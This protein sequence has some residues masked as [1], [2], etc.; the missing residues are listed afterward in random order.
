MK[1][2]AFIATALRTQLAK[3]PALTLLG[4]AGLA[5]AAICLA[6]ALI[7]GV[8]ISPEGNL[9]DTATFDAALGF[10]MLTLAVLASGIPWRSRERRVWTSLLIGLTLYA[11]A[12][13]TV[14]AFRGLDPRFSRVAGSIDQAAGGIFFLVALAIMLCFTTVAVKY[15]L[16]PATPLTVGVRYGALA[17]WVAFGVGIWMS[18]VT[19]GRVVPEAGNLLVVHALGFHGLQ[20]IPGVALLLRW[21]G[22]AQSVARRRVHCA[23]LAWLTACLAV[24]WQS[25]TGRPI[26]E[27]SPA[28]AGAALCL[29]VFGLAVFL[30][31]RAWLQSDALDSDRQPASPA[32][33]AAV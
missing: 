12:I 6:A 26:A 1:R 30:A 10:F 5:L 14:Q 19:R 18:L 28:T 33:D 15:F 20:T 32:R 22:T 21:T 13:E 7:R 25:G 31:V 27:L 16:A 8:E 4:L 24:A 3:W 29:S 2:A 17:S 9:L 11:Y 23:G